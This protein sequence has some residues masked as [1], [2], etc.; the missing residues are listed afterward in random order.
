ML[1]IL[2]RPRVV[3][4]VIEWRRAIFK[5]DVGS[6]NSLAGFAAAL[7]EEHALPEL[8]DEETPLADI[9]ADPPALTL[10]ITRALDA[11][12][13]AGARRESRSR[14]GRATCG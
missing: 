3:E 6:Q 12:N 1:P 2:T 5:P 7:V 4:H 13:Q 11:C 14:S 8:A 10:A 9:L